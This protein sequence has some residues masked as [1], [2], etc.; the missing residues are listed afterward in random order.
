MTPHEREAWLAWRRGGIGASDVPALLGTSP[1]QTE[2]DVWASK[3]HGA[4]R[5]EE[6]ELAL[7]RALEPAILA[8]A[9][10]ELGASLLPG[11]RLES[12]ILRGTTD[13]A[14]L[15]DGA[16]IG[17]EAKSA[18][19]PTE[20]WGLA[21]D[22]AVPDGYR[23]QVLTYCE[24]TGSPGWFLAV[25]FTGNYERRLYWIPADPERQRV[26]RATAEAWHELHVV[27]GEMPD[28]DASEACRRALVERYARPR[29]TLREATDAE[30]RLALDFRAVQR[31]GD[32]I[33]ADEDRLRNELRAAIGPDEG[34]RWATGRVT[35]HRPSG[36]ITVRIRA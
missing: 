8:W 24:L 34:I 17:I 29:A 25:W 7:G 11:S 16:P 5:A 30:I 32:A 26:I 27:G 2:W 35:F 6:P 14:M 3:A 1:W 18:R 28:P 20:A 31:A 13:G 22:G 12:G 33:D 36:R 4:D 9:A 10:D 19:Y 21:P 15:I 23:D